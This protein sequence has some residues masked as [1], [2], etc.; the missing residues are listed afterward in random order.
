MYGPDYVRD[1]AYVRIRTHV[2]YT[3]L[4]NSRFTAGTYADTFTSLAGRQRSALPYRSTSP[5][6]SQADHARAK[7]E[8]LVGICAAALR[9][10]FLRPLPRRPARPG[11]DAIAGLAPR[12]RPSALGDPGRPRRHGPRPG[13]RRRRLRRAVRKTCGSPSRRSPRLGGV[14]GA[15]RHFAARAAS[16]GDGVKPVLDRPRQ[17]PIQFPLEGSRG[18][19]V[20]VLVV[21]EDAVDLDAGRARGLLIQRAPLPQLPPCPASYPL[22]VRRPPSRRRPRASAMRG[23]RDGWSSMTSCSHCM[24]SRGDARRLVVLVVGAVLRP[25]PLVLRRVGFGGLAVEGLLV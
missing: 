11:A 7:I 5:P 23:S 20:V 14:L 24:M 4:V 2:A 15:R 16:I 1:V 19:V 25:Q 17:V 18:R 12:R 21:V 6:L 13:R 22:K 3:V 8:Q 9:A 10:A